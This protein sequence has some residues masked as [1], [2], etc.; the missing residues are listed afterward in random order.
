MK[1][2]HWGGLL[3]SQLELIYVSLA[4]LKNSKS[5]QIKCFKFIFLFYFFCLLQIP[6]PLAAYSFCLQ[7]LFF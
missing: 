4:G 1:S 2:F 3:I 7:D 5:T 6:F